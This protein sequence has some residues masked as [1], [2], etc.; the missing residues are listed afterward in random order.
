MRTLVNKKIF[1]GRTKWNTWN[2]TAE[3]SV[4]LDSPGQRGK[5]PCASFWLMII[6]RA[7]MAPNWV[8]TTGL[9]WKDGWVEVR[10]RRESSEQKSTQWEKAYW[11]LKWSPGTQLKKKR[12]RKSIA[13]WGTLRPEAGAGNTFLLWKQARRRR[14]LWGF[15]VHREES[16]K[17]SSAASHTKYSS[18]L[19]KLGATKSSQ[20]AVHDTLRK[21]I[22]KRT[23]ERGE[24]NGKVL[25]K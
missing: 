22:R 16:Y 10:N 15:K 12:L 17:F 9:G 4:T 23:R 24:W 21:Q 2:V 5:V 14:Q 18:V 3:T 8:S 25:G 20:G 1:K 11:A 6:N 19:A 7:L 13:F